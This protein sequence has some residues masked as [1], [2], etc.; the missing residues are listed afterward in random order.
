[1]RDPFLAGCWAKVDR[2][3]EHIKELDSAL[4]AWLAT[5]PYS[6][7]SEF[8]AER[9]LRVLKFDRFPAVPL[10][11]AAI[12]GDAIHN[13]RSALDHFVYRLA[14]L[15]SQQ[16][17]PPKAGK[18]GFPICDTPE[19]LDRHR[20]SFGDLSTDIT[21]GLERFQ[22]F[23]THSSNPHESAL[24]HLEQ[25]DIID[26]HRGFNLAVVIWGP[27]ITFGPATTGD[28]TL[29]G[30]AAPLPLKPETELV[31]YTTEKPDAYVDF[32]PTFEIA[33]AQE[34]SVPEGIRVKEVLGLFV[35]NV[36][37]VLASAKVIRKA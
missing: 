32:Q 33:F 21:A 27:E 16:S 20:Q 25:L 3:H 4:E 34:S 10:S 1:V 24:W 37:T 28:V 12:I 18:L 17:P 6:F 35:G 7:K 30:L 31:Q 19:Q 5:E 8:D 9:G 22:P 36:E 14:I 15:E 13:L 2:A 11:L 23:V 26:K 29:H